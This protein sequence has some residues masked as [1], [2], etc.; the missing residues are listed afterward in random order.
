MRGL[1]FYLQ[2]DAIH[3]PA[4]S[5]VKVRNEGN[6]L[7]FRRLSSFGVDFAPIRILK[8]SAGFGESQFNVFN[9]API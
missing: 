8:T 6:A 5:P 7:E 2:Q 9:S 4:A 1:N 3:M